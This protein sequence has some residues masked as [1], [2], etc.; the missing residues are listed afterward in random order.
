MA[1]GGNLTAL[2]QV[3]DKGEKNLIGEREHQ[4]SNVVDLCGWLD[5]SGGQNNYSTMNAKIQETTHIFICGF[6]SC[7]GLSKKWVWNPFSLTNGVITTDKQDE[8]VDVTSENGR[9]VIDG[10]IYDIL[11]I[12]DPMNMHQHLEIYLKYVGGGQGVN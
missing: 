5:Y 6:H 7:K 3:K 8:K 2:V 4:W 1:I 10:N 9:M 12:D 11:L